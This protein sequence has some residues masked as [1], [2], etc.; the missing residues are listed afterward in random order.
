MPARLAQIEPSPDVFAAVMATGI[1]SIAA[2]KHYYHWISDILGV[3]ATLG[4]LV[5]VA[6]V[7]SAGAIRSW[8]LTDPDVT[9]A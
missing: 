7:L 6:V 2:N 1:L 3:L 9:L 5:L 4:L 8:D